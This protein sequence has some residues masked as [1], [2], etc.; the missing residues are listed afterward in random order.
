MSIYID[1]LGITSDR[2]ISLTVTEVEA[3]DE[4]PLS[5]VFVALP[6][7]KDGLIG[8]GRATLSLPSM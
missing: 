1:H 4:V 8:L 6:T 3:F 2:V 7:E 5:I